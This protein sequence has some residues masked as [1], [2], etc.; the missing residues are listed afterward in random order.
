MDKYTYRYLKD[1]TLNDLD[2][3]IIERVPV[4]GNSGYTK[5]I[6]WIDKEHY[7]PQKLEYYDR[8]DEILK[9]LQFFD[10]KLY[11]DNF[12]RAHRWEMVNHQTSKSTTLDWSNFQFKTELSERDFNRNVL[13]SVR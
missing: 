5:Q 6:V 12:W 4:Y 7:R 2:C 1:E 11:Y 3:F 13:K 9:T 8:K 10:Y